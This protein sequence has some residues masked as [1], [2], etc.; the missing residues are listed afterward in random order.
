M[1]KSRSG[2]KSRHGLRPR[3]STQ[4]RGWDADSLAATNVALVKVTWRR[5]GLIFLAAVWIWLVLEAFPANG[6]RAGFSPSGPWLTL[7]APIVKA[8]EALSTVM[9]MEG[10]IFTLSVAIVVGTR[11]DGASPENLLR[12]SSWFETASTVIAAL[13][14][15]SLSVGISHIVHEHLA[16]GAWV[17]PMVS[18]LGVL[19]AAAT[20]EDGEAAMKIREAMRPLAMRR[21]QMIRARL[22]GWGVDRPPPKMRPIVAYT[23]LMVVALGV[24]VL[25]LTVQDVAW[26]SSAYLL[27]IVIDGAVLWL[28]SAGFLFFSSAG[29]WFLRGMGVRAA[30]V[31]RWVLV[32]AAVAFSVP[33]LIHSIAD[34]W[35]FYWCLLFA[36]PFFTAAVLSATT[37]LRGWNPY[38]VTAWIAVSDVGE[39]V[40]R[41]DP[42]RA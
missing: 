26:L 16:A 8:S 24:D 41:G 34:G 15:L 18:I 11:L 27:L 20:Y 36:P 7:G 3:S 10:L 9:A 28:A 29:V 37:S 19:V 2:L 21:Q 1:R 25:V 13:A 4:R 35:F 30:E 31:V 32:L 39:K 6:M 17:V 42:A 38:F 23:G 12:L 14:A 40:E 5:L 22:A 33:A